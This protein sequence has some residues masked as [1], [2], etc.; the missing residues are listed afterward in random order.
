MNNTLKHAGITVIAISPMV[1]LASIWSKVPANVPVHFGL[2][3]PDAWGS[4]ASLWVIGGIMAGVSL[5]AY[6][7]LINISKV[8]PKRAAAPASEVFGKLAAG[9]VL[10]IAALNFIAMQ[11]SGLNAQ[12]TDMVMLLMGLMFAFL[13]NLMHNIKPNYFA[14]IRLPWTLASDNNWRLTHRVAGK[15]WFGGGLVLAVV[16]LVLQ[17]K[18]VAL[19]MP[20]LLGVMVAVP[21]VYSFLLYRQEQKAM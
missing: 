14:G 4:R 6:T 20:F 19:I 15:L 10:F 2:N 1:Y 12:L 21:I 16:A 13:G 18:V 17:P 7:L 11:M 8:D 5:L 3:G 9:M